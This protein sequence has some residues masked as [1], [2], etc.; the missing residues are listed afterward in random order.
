MI[1]PGCCLVVRLGL[2]QLVEVPRMWISVLYIFKLKL[3]FL[4]IH[5]AQ[6]RTYVL[7]LSNFLSQWQ[8]QDGSDACALGKQEK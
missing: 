7:I 5:A 6:Y 2:L 4:N 8:P 3:D 1:L